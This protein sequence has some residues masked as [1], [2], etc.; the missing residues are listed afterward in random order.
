MNSGSGDWVRLLVPDVPTAAD[1]RPYME[2]MDARR[3][4]TNF[5]P[6]AGRFEAGLAEKLGISRDEVVAFSNCTLTLEAALSAL[7]PPA[8]QV[9]V[10]A[11]TF[12][13]TAAAVCR[14][15]GKPIYSDICEK[16]WL[17]T[18]AIAEACLKEWKIDCVVPVAAFGCPQPTD[19][20]DDFTRKTGIPVLVDAAGAFGNQRIGVTTSCAFSFH[21][22]KCLGIGEGGAL[23][24]KDRELIRKVRQFEN[25]GINV[26]T[27]RVELLGTNAK[28]SE[29]HAA[30]GLAALER[31]DRASTYRA[32]IHRA[33][34]EKLRLRCP[35]VLLQDRKIDGIYSILQVLLPVGMDRDAVSGLLRQAG[36]ETRAWYLP[37][38][39]DHPAFATENAWD[40]PV[41]RTLAPRML[42]LPFH[43]GL[44]NGQI[45][46]VCQ[47]L[48][49]LLNGR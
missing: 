45:D 24:S 11:L 3:W 29:L 34:S 44:D 7:L 38:V 2:E 28:L 19:E 18:P 42:G 39:P 26:D 46:R 25:F 48:A 13:A 35:E 23:I 27:G 32:E 37:L 47:S 49:N 43:P 12:V 17:L 41:S 40:I 31:W 4:Y 14:A 21:A 15:G 22:T 33:Y 36:I 16:S 1:V 20:W 9:L 10:P 30:V 8:G 6:L 5:G